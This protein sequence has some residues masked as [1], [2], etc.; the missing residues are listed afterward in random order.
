[1]QIEEE[2]EV[3]LSRKLSRRKHVDVKYEDQPVEGLLTSVKKEEEDH[4]VAQEYLLV[5]MGNKES[6]TT[7]MFHIT[8]IYDAFTC[9]I[10]LFV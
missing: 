1:M 10:K 6:T 8:W 7:K 2:K 3:S 9:F 4:S 5:C